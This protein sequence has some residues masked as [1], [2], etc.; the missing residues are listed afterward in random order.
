MEGQREYVELMHETAMILWG[1]EEAEKM[2][3]HIET[4][5]NAVC[6]NAQAML[7]IS[8]EPAIRLRHR[9]QP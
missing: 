9:E 8:L 4:T 2:H 3:S 7:P 6:I 5:A 1:K